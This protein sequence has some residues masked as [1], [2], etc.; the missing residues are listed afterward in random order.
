[1]GMFTVGTQAMI[2]YSLLIYEADLTTR[3]IILGGR[4]TLEIGR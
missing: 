1:M 2:K 4:E 3:F